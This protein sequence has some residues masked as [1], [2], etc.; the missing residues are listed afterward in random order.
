MAE[1]FPNYDFIILYCE[2]KEGK[3]PIARKVK[4]YNNNNNEFRES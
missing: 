2:G 3:V 1:I 4:L